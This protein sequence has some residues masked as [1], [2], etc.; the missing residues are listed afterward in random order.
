MTIAGNA[1]AYV[2]LE[3]ESIIITSP[4]V[5]KTSAPSEHAPVYGDTD[6]Q[7]DCHYNNDTSPDES[8]G[9][10]KQCLN[11]CSSIAGL[12]LTV[13]ELVEAGVYVSYPPAIAYTF[14]SS[15]DPPEIHPPDFASNSATLR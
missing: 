13:L 5:I 3:L 8:T 15:I 4:G 11:Y 6:V 2:P 14:I 1:G 9:S 12:L 10:L 7:H